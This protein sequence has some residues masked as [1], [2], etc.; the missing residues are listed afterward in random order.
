[1][2]VNS[3]QPVIL[4]GPPRGVRGQLEVHND[5]DRTVSRSPRLVSMGSAARAAKSGR[6]GVAQ[7]LQGA[8]LALRRIVVRPHTHCA[9]PISLALNPYTAP[10]MYEAKLEID[11]EHHDVI[12]HVTEEISFSITPDSLV[13]PNRPGEKFERHVMVVNR[14]NV[15]LVIRSIGAVVLDDE[16]AGCRAIRGALHE[17]GATM[18]SVD[19]FAAALGHQLTKIYDTQTLKVQNDKLTLEPG[20]AQSLE[21]TIS[22][23]EKLNPRARYSGF[24]AI[25]TGNLDFT[26][27]P[28]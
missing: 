6:S 26:I 10:G 13:L 21:L 25:S 23:P 17:A 27:V 7:P 2:L 19:D 24:A 1:M 3:E 20:K 28:E 11:E 22:L 4:S 9:V 15:P 18:K 5:S 16:L 14:G 12:V 8:N